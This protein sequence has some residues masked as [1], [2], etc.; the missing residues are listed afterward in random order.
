[1]PEA[2]ALGR[3]RWQV[4]LLFKLWKSEGRIDASRGQ[5]PFRAGAGKEKELMDRIVSAEPESL[6]PAVDRHLEAIV[7]KCLAK[8]PRRRFATAAAV[9]TELQRWLEQNAEAVL[10]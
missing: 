2:L 3:S 1:M 4:E 10:P 6:S 5:R 7:L 9:A 8:D